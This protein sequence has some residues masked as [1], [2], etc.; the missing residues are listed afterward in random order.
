MKTN[1]S[2]LMSLISNEEKNINNKIYGLSDIATSTSIEE[3]DG[4]VNV[5]EDNEKSFKTN[6]E[7]IEESIKKLSKLKEILYRK[8]N[9]YKLSDNRTIQEAI[10]DN[11]YLRK[12]KEVYEQLL[13]NK[14][15]KKRVTEVNNSY[16][17]CKKVNFDIDE[18]KKKL[19][20]VDEKIHKTDFEI[21]KLNSIEFEI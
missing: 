13:L 4:R 16:F 17:E 19:E 20:E 15:S 2:S 11:T 5:V 10:V 7:D 12:L 1:I 18:I 3:L 14:T 6:L 9:E 8:N 21:S